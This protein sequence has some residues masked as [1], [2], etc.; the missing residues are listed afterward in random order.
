MPAREE[1][2]QLLHAWC[3]GDQEALDRLLPYVY[4][5]L[6][7]L[8]ASHLRRERAGHTLQATA[9]V[10]EAYLRLVDDTLPEFQS[11][12]HF[13]GIAARAMRQ[14]LVEHARARGAAKRGG[15]AARLS[16][17]DIATLAEAGSPGI[18]DLDEALTRLAALDARKSRMIELR[19]FGG[20]TIDEISALEGCSAATVGRD[21]RF[22][23]SWLR[24]EMSA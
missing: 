3:G 15:G 20:L 13:F 8:A 17:D 2:T 19:H 6:R 10:H 24:R 23:E 7:V 14:I 21:L 22:A 16:L 4:S 12:S 9:L 11:R 5:E 18:L 1:V